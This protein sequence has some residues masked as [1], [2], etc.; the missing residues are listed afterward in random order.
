M[1]TKRVLVFCV[2]LLVGCAL[3]WLGGYD[4]DSR[5]LGVALAVGCLLIVAGLVATDPGLIE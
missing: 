4:F 2:I 3:A 1:N 5:G